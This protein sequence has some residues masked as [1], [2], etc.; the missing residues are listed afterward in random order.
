LVQDRLVSANPGKEPLS[1]A[2]GNPS[3]SVA[4][5]FTAELLSVAIKFASAP[6]TMTV[7]EERTFDAQDGTI[8]SL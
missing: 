1:V 3:G 6:S 8:E 4:A 7:A 5:R 2:E